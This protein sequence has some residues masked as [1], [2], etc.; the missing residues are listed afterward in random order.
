MHEFEMLQV[1]LVGRSLVEASAG[2]GKTYALSTLLVRLLLEQ[3]HTIDQILVVTFTEAATMELKDRVRRR[4]QQAISILEALERPGAE[5]PSNAD[6]ILVDLARQQR[7]PKRALAALRS[8]LNSFDDAAIFTI[9]GFCHRVLQENAFFSGVPFEAE[10]LRD[11]RPMVEEVLLDYWSRTVSSSSLL[12]VERLRQPGRQLTPN[13][14]KS[15]AQWVAQTKQLVVLPEDAPLPAELHTEAFCKAFQH[16]AEL[17]DEREI[18]ELLLNAGLHGNWYRKSSI[19]EWCKELRD[20][21]SS[22]VVLPQVPERFEKFTTS[23]L[24][25]AARAKAAPEHPFFDACDELLEQTRQFEE[26]VDTHILGFMRGL[27]NYVQQQMPARKEQQGLLSFDDLLGQLHDALLAAS[28]PALAGAIRQRYPAALIDEFQD[29]D[30]TQYSIF[31]RIYA[32]SANSMFLIGDPKQAIYSFRGA[33]VFAYLVAA[34]SVKPERRYTMAVNYRSDADL[35][36]ATNHLFLDSP[37]PFFIRDIGFPDV[38]ANQ[39]GE[40]ALQIPEALGSAP[41]QFRFCQREQARSSRYAPSG[42]KAF[43][44]NFKRRELPALVARE[45]LDLLQSDATLNGRAL[46]PK[47]FAILTRTNAE[48]FDCQRALQALRIPSVVQ[49]DRSVYEYEE[50]AELQLPLAAVLEPANTRA[51][52][53]ALTTEM[54]GLTA[55]QLLALDTDDAAWDEWIER[56]RN[57]NQR[58]VSDGFVQMIRQVMQG[59]GISERLLGLIDGER[60]MTNLLHLVELLHTASTTQHLGPSGLFQHLAQQRTR[61]FAIKDS[62]QIRLESDEDAVVLTTIHKSK[63]LEY[64]IVIC[65]TLFN[66]MLVHPGDRNTTRFHDSDDHNRL[67]LDL[68]STRLA[69]HQE[70]MK[71]EAMAENLRLL[72]VALTRARHRTVV[73][74]GAFREF[75]TSAL[76]YLLH[77]A[78]FI[79]QGKAPSIDLCAD[80]L[81]NRHDEAL[82]KRLNDL[83][84]N[85][86][87]ISVATIDHQ[88][89]KERLQSP[90]QYVPGVVRTTSLECR[91]VK[92]PIQVWARTAS[93][94]ELS[95]HDSSATH[96]LGPAVVEGRDTDSTAVEPAAPRVRA[97][98]RCRLAEF[99]GGAQTGNLFH[100]LLEHADFQAPELESATIETAL[101]AHGFADPQR[102][103]DTSHTSGSGGSTLVEL[104]QGAIEDFLQTEI[105]PGLRLAQLPASQRLNEMEFHLPAAGD[106]NRPITPAALG[107]VFESHPSDALPAEYASELRKLNFLPLEGY[108]KGFIDLMFVHHTEAGERYYVVDYKTNNLGEHY[109]AYEHAALMQAMQH[110]HYYLQYHLYTLAVHRYLEQRVPN[111]D[112]EQSFGGVYYLFLR[113]MHPDNGAR[114]GVFYEKPPPARLQ[115]LSELFPARITGASSLGGAA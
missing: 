45:V 108:L 95:T 72:Y 78:Q 22:P 74:W 48:A 40:S 43:D 37:A 109:A 60:R 2:T 77:S 6:P 69:A 55:E 86:A 111:Y 28:G 19:P 65:P 59:C 68:G 4:I 13:T 41:F 98:Q 107:Q 36:A 52:R 44:W 91:L 10:L 56:F 70:L 46:L 76:G 112:Y 93:F 5:V 61:E 8:A 20:Y 96:S 27:V 80:Y 83:A 87:G 97:D 26:Q 32:G 54:L 113:G 81:R 29:T 64:P 35:V 34:Q 71:E 101:R 73:F 79:P 42:Q 85:C 16:A 84:A 92:S 94:T 104:V 31:E 39:Q 14:L 103:V 7:Q 75:Q 23:S 105:Q 57:Y 51:I 100:D 66:G 17:F 99:P 15:F 63:G 88:Q 21:F 115:A 58:W 62:E 53:A 25:S 11:T 90:G 89:V 106:A 3:R 30:P 67:K 38:H 47:D 9:H 12:F 49:G 114:S 82:L 33:D 102:R 110:S 24:R 50:A 18:R 1:P